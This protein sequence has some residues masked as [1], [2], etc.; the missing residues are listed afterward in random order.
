MAGAAFIALMMT[1]AF[2]WRVFIDGDTNWHVAAGRW[3]LAHHTVP[4]TDPFSYTFAG[5]P[6]VAH[7]WLSEVLM[8]GAY[9]IAGWSGVVLFI[10]VCAGLA[11]AMIAAELRLWMG[12]VGQVVGVA[13]SFACLQPFLFAR[14]H[15]V[16]MPLLVFW[17][18]ALLKARREG[19]AP[20][21]AITPLMMLWAN[22][23]G[24]FIFG[25]AIIGPFAAEALFA[26][27]DKL[28]VVREWAVFGLVSLAFS[29]LTP[30]GV[31]ELIF[32]FMV[33]GMKILPDILEWRGATFGEPTLFEGALLATLFLGLWRGVRV[34]LWRLILLLGL[35]HMALQHVRQ[36]SV[37]AALAPLLLAEPFGRALTP[38]R[39]GVRGVM[40]AGWKP[41]W[42][43]PSIAVAATLTVIGLGVAGVRLAQPLVRRDNANV[44]VS[45]MA[46]VPPQYLSQPVL[47]EYAFGGYLIFKGVKPFID[48]RADMYGDDFVFEYLALVGGQQPDV[49]QAFKRW[50]IRWTILAPK[51]ALV[52]TLDAAPNWKR[53]YSDPF[54][55]V[56]VETAPPGDTP[57]AIP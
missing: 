55:V 42:R 29:L 50:N 17:C 22:L 12:P 36:D 48:G 26:E 3:I 52:R 30:R 20:P 24:S 33:V 57:G 25:L 54:A 46:H 2:S 18:R 28:K 16:A 41:D 44:P 9:L 34:P 19:R 11:Y 7:E 15:I 56:H 32:P 39:A 43:V 4:R 10:G 14:P 5:K 37:L 1:A 53:V 47:N 23:H 27:A 13:L 31:D 8:A 49:S 51:D 21:L 35:V 38:Q 6:W 45:A 40:P